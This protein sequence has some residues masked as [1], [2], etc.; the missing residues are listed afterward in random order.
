MQASGAAAGDPWIQVKAKPLP[1]SRRRTTAEQPTAR[2]P[3]R[4]VTLN[5]AT[6]AGHG[7]VPAPLPAAGAPGDAYAAALA[8]DPAAE[9]VHNDAA[10]ASGAAAAS[11]MDVFAVVLAEMAALRQQVQQEAAHTREA[12]AGQ[13]RFPVSHLPANVARSEHGCSKLRPS[14]P[15]IEI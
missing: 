7:P 12:V 9:A 4:A 5:G 6:A 8:T 2:L 14:L 3:V 1:K 10:R 15:C 11:G 13:V